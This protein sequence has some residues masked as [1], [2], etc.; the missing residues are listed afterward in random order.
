M[1]MKLAIHKFIIFVGGFEKF[2][3]RLFD[4]FLMHTIW[5]KDKTKNAGCNY[6]KKITSSGL[7]K[8]TRTKKKTC[9]TYCSGEN[10]YQSGIC[11]FHSKYLRNLLCEQLELEEWIWYDC[12]FLH[13]TSMKRE[14]MSTCVGQRSCKLIGCMDCLWYGKRTKRW[15]IKEL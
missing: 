1:K 7:R 11:N 4:R 9:S 10:N 12:E 6:R 14:M 5:E 13:R 15:M 8:W 3:C 2:A